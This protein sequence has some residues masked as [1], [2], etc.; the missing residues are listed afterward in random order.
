MIQS[1]VV[2]IRNRVKR[3]VIGELMQ[4]LKKCYAEGGDM[5]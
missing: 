5:K 3:L 2:Q 1:N 4:C